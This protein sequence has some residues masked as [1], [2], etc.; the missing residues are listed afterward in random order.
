[1]YVVF[2]VWGVCIVVMN[3]FICC[4]V[5]DYWVYVTGGYIEK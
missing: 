1:M 3:F 4:V 5:V 2:I